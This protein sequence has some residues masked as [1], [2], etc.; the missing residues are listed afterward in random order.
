MKFIVR[1]GVMAFFWSTCFM[2]S[3]LIGVGELCAIG[4]GHPQSEMKMIITAIFFFYT[5]FRTVN[6]IYTK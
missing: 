4:E 2:L 5:G 3:F 6:Y 1:H